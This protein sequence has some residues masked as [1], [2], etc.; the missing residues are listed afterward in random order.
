MWNVI[1]LHSPLE[2]PEKRVAVPSFLGVIRARADLAPYLRELQKIVNYDWEFFDEKFKKFLTLRED[3]TED[4][5]Q[6]LWAHIHKVLIYLGK[7]TPEEWCSKEEQAE[8]FI[9]NFSAMSVV[10]F[11]AKKEAL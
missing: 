11:P 8:R 10:S 5:Q 9:T 4:I 6:E 7:I 2:E 3:A 1:D